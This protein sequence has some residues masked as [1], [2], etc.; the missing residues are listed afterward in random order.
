MPKLTVSRCATA[1]R[2]V[3]LDTNVLLD[4][5][6]FRDPAS[7]HLASTAFS[8]A[9]HWIGS[10]AT[11][12]ELERVLR[13]LPIAARLQPLGNSHNE[14]L[15]QYDARVR[16]VEPAPRCAAI[17]K[18]KDDQKFIDLAV[19]HSAV[20]LSK[21]KAVLALQRK[22]KTLGVCAMRAEEFKS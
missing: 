22:L 3:V 14:V 10:A 7:L 13:Y 20:L 8:P 15:E 16:Q 2:A 18:D 1:P 19:A 11:R 5:L 9:W 17:C 21:D 4:L 6:V 12:E